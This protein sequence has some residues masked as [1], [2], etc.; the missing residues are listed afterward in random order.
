ME[1]ELRK[2]QEPGPNQVK[3]LAYQS[4]VGGIEIVAGEK[5]LLAIH[6]TDSPADLD[7]SDSLLQDCRIQLDEYFS[8]VR[9]RFDLALDMQGTEFQIQVWAELLKIP[10]G[11][12][13]SY[14]QIAKALGDPKSSRAVGF[15]N[16]KN[17][18]SIVVPCHRVIGANGNL[19]GYAGGIEKKKWLLGFER[20]LA[21]K[22][23][24]NSFI[25][26]AEHG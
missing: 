25:Q 4:P 14:M 2:T 21:I 11:A 19:V 1:T 6:F 22:D 15:A 26:D 24:F 16:G 23:L 10:F 17:P 12:T 3:K 7:P 8:G 18:F 5:G 20:N 9:T 13:V